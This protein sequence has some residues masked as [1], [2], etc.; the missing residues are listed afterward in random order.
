[1]VK[2]F[3]YVNVSECNIDLS[4]KKVVI[5][6]ISKS[7]LDLYVALRAKGTEVLGFT[8]S[9]SENGGTFCELPIYSVEDVKNMKNMVIYVSTMNQ[10]YLRDILDIL[11]GTDNTV[12]CKTGVYGC[13]LY[14]IKQMETLVEKDS[15]KI[16]EVAELF[17]DEKSIKTYNNLIKYRLTNERSL[18]KEIYE[19][20][21]A[22]Y[23]PTGGEIIIPS[24]DEIFVDAGGYNGATSVQFA[25]WVGNEYEKIYIMEPDDVMACVTKEYI[26]MR[27]LKN[28]E[29]VKRGAYSESTVLKFQNL[30]VNGS[31]YITDEGE[32]QIETISIDEMLKGNRASYIKMDIEGAEMEALDGASA[33]ISKF[34]PKLAISVYHK[35]DDLWNI[36]FYLHKKYP[37]YR[38]YLR[39]YTSITTETILYA[40]EQA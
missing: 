14:D 12:L 25:A 20:Q 4:D 28:V 26:K 13:G 6:G 39:H 19:N 8:D 16:K 30:F 33:T 1:M 22:Q 34:R 40:V 24:N 23:F 27:N 10:E 35:E 18:I 7:A 5:Y 3:N 21:H 38:F 36:P 31:S 2:R 32:S 37:W 11:D 9:F 17:T 29:L 15:D